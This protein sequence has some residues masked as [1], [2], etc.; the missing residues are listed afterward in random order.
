MISLV[1]LRD[2]SEKKKFRVPE[3]RQKESNL[4]EARGSWAINH[5]NP[6]T[7]MKIILTEF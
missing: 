7:K 1:L 5:L 2:F 4:Q 6:E 3:F